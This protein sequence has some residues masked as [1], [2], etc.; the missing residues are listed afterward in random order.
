[1]VPSGIAAPRCS[2]LQRRA[3]GLKHRQQDQVRPT[4]LA[5]PAMIW[6]S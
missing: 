5:Q 6:R 2:L 3:S 1:V 4:A